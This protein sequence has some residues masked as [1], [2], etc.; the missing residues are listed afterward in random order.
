[1]RRTATATACALGAILMS[2]LGAASALA[3]AAPEPAGTAAAVLPLLILG[4]IVV[5]VLVVSILGL[6]G[7][8]R[9]RHEKRTR[10]EHWAERQAIDR[11]VSRPDPP[12][13]GGDE[14]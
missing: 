12:D 4:G 8:A 3:D 5:G 14:R 9:S 11:G 6:R 2:L 1:M 7:I 13:S 10:D